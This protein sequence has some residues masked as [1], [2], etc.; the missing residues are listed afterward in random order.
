MNAEVL[1]EP[2]EIVHPLLEGEGI[3]GIGRFVRQATADVVGDDG[4]IAVAQF[5]HQLPIVER[6]AWV[7]VKH[8]DRIALALVEIVVFETVEVEEVTFE[9][10][11]GLHHH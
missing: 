3:V 1:E 8:D 9:G 6:P 11:V 4:P 7:A 2:F 10:I 5:P